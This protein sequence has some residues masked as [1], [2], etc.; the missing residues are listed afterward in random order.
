[1]RTTTST[2]NGLLLTIDYP[3]NITF[4]YSPQLVRITGDAPAAAKASITV[5][6]MDSGRAHTETRSF[7]DGAAQFDISHMMQ[8]LSPDVDRLFERLDY[9]TGQTLSELFEFRLKYIADDEET[10][11]LYR[12]DIV[13]MYG[14]L[15]PG[16]T[17][18][19]SSQR[20]L[21][22]NFPQTFNLWQDRIGEVLF[23]FGDNDYYPALN[24]NRPC[25][26]CNFIG[27]LGSTAGFVPGIAQELW[28][29]WKARV[30]NGAE[31]EEDFRKVTLIPENCTMYDGTYLRW[32]NRRGEVSYWLFK[33]SQIRVTSTVDK[34]FM[35]YYGN[36]PHKPLGQ[37]FVNCQKADYREAREVVIGAIGLSREEYEDLCDLATSPLVERLI[38]PQ[39]ELIG[40]NTIIDG[41]G[42]ASGSTAYDG[43]EASADNDTIISAT[44][45]GDTSSVV[46]Y[47]WQRVN[48]TAG[49]YA[50][51]ISRPTPSRQDLEFIIELP[52]R[53]TIKL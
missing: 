22:L 44:G 28:L 37:S 42:A 6:H 23:A 50:R 51:S 35:R 11:I 27:T 36:D 10:E 25:Y 41:G 43:G 29:T 2:V 34:N 48:V 47:Q 32:L 53:N 24:G 3:N 30:E 18:G 9:E 13:A 19:K 17:Y 8:L 15:D 26:E 12:E 39:E 38:P 46:T 33:N 14:A 49:S 40:M 5:K 20:R 16:E 45:D 21:W 7:F 31:T 1:M 52:E 4:M